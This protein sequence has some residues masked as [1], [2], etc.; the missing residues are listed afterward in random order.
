VTTTYSDQLLG[1]Q[2]LQNG[3]TTQ[4]FISTGSFPA[5][6][7]A[8][9]QELKT[10]AVDQR[11]MQDSYTVVKTS[12]SV[13]VPAG[14]FTVIELSGSGATIYVDL[15]SGLLVKAVGP[16][17]TEGTATI[18]LQSTNIATSATSFTLILIIVIIVV[19]VAVLVPTLLLV[20]RKRS[21][22]KAAAASAAPQPPT[23]TPA[24]M[25]Q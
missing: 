13:S 14:T 24:T 1:Q 2:G 7:D 5:M 11:V 10:A 3:R 18:E 8:Q 19:V 20:R 6:T 17:V 16:L 25:A 4:S 21:K 15:T 23:M 9:F 22:A 12:T